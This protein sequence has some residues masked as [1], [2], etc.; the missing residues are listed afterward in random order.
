LL[1]KEAIKSFKGGNAS[2]ESLALVNARK[3]LGAALVSD[4]KYKEADDVFSDVKL[5]IDKQAGV[6]RKIPAADLDWVIAMLKVGKHTNAE[7]MTNDMLSSAIKRSNVSENRLNYLQAFNAMAIHA[8]GKED[9]AR[10]N[11]R[12]VMPKL[13]ERVR[14]DAENQTSST[15]QQERMVLILEDNISLLAKQTKTHPQI[16]AQVA[17]E[18]YSLADLARGSSVQ[19]ALNASC[20]RQHQRPSVGCI[21]PQ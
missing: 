11:Y 16:A 10:E 14:N 20:T 21:G 13:I 6:E 9:Q 4:R 2:D 12:K 3:S 19:R 18:A 7:E 8:T 15:K 17:A 5:G 1:A